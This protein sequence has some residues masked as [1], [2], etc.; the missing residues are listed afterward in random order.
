MGVSSGR[1]VARRRRHRLTRGSHDV[2]RLWRGVLGQDRGS[3][4]IHGGRLRVLTGALP[5]QR[6]LAE[7]GRQLFS[8]GGMGMMSLVGFDCHYTK[9]K[10]R[11]ISMNQDNTVLNTCV[12]QLTT[13][14][15]AKRQYSP[16][17]IVNQ[18]LAGILSRILEK[19]SHCRHHLQIYKAI[20]HLVIGHDLKWAADLCASG[21]SMLV[22]LVNLKLW[23]KV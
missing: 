21:I 9:Y 10:Y 13:A 8:L 18:K 19:A 3:S 16:T 23:C 2:A 11:I 14:S 15:C 4:L 6:H 5:T 12:I 22:P 17:G 1:L 7:L 20:D